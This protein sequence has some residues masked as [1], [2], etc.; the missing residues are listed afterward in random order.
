MAALYDRWSQ[1][2]DI[3]L[4][5][6]ELVSEGRSH[7]SDSI[8]NFKNYLLR[9]KDYDQRFLRDITALEKTAAAYAA[10]GVMDLREQAALKSIA[11]GIG[12]YRTA[13][14]KAIEMKA[15]GASIEDIDSS[16]EGADKPLKKAFEDLV[17]A[18]REQTEKAESSVTELVAFGSRAVVVVSLSTLLIGSLLAWFISRRIT[19]P[20][21]KS[22]QIAKTVASGDLTSDI[23]VGSNDETGQLARALSD[24]NGS[25]VHLIG[26]VR[27]GAGVIAVAAQQIA[28]GNQEL[29]SRTEAQASSLEQTAASMEELTSNVKQ[30]TDSAR[31]ANSLALSATEVAGKGG[32]VV[33]KVVDTMKSI[34]E[35]SKKIVDI[36]SVI[37]G[38]AFQT[39]IL[40]LNAA[41]EAARAGEQGR[42]FAVVAS[43]VRSLAQRS[44]TAAT[45][46]KQLIGDS[47]EKVEVGSRLVEQAGTT[48]NEIVTSIKNVNT[49]MAEIMSASE[50]QSTGIEEVNKA[51]VLMDGV[52][53]QNAALVEEAASAATSLH[54]QSDALAR[55]VS[56]FKLHTEAETIRH[57]AVLPQASQ[58]G[59]PTL[60]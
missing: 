34:S 24:M 40:A 36:I 52:A 46:I 49:I 22:V 50:E 15:A 6:M 4:Q 1:F 56:I 12:V 27:T 59:A 38:I 33:T 8:Q 35:S 7:L 3:P 14:G 23:E 17:L 31:R 60:A 28:S 53:Q 18:T 47:V 45:E 37:D 30:N 11:D 2:R 39:N 13:I 51:M 44:A 20:L 5:K 57:A 25:L 54:T 9:S 55:A 43:E 41:V 10:L 58:S 48:M 26:K 19:A 32:S 16:I 42:G 29:S 21:N